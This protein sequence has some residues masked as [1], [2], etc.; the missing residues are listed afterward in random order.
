MPLA[1]QPGGLGGVVVAGDHEVA[2]FENGAPVELAGHG[3]RRAGSL[4]R[5][6]QR[7]AGTE[8]GLR[9]D[10]GVVVAFPAHEVA[11]GQRHPQAA[12]GQLGGAVL[13]GGSA[14]D[15]DC[16]VLRAHSLRPLGRSVTRALANSSSASASGRS[17]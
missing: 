17:L 15:D 2:P 3:L 8:Q 13:P 7:L 9:R 11:L 6:L 4:A 16:V 12:L 5:R 14:A 1:L 10:A